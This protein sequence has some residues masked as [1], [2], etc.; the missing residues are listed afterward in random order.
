MED[1]IYKGMLI[2]KGSIVIGNLRGMTLNA[3]VYQDPYRF[4]P[5]RY[6]PKPAG[7]GE[8]FSTSHFG[9]GR[10]ICPGRHLADDNLWIAIATTL[11]TIK[12]SKALD[13]NGKEI[14]PDA[15]PIATGVSR[16]SNDFFVPGPD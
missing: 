1:D 13:V 12:F 10:R 11:A 9:F 3:S 15:T 7:R 2:P 16:S 8:P 4:D 14:T 5:S 6:L